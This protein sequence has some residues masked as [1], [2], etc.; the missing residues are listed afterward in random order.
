[1]SSHILLKGGT[2]F[3][4]TEV[5]AEGFVEIDGAR[6]GRVGALRDLTSDLDATVIDTAGCTVSPGFI[7]TH[8][9][10]LHQP[11]ALHLSEGATA[12]WGANYLAGVLRSGVTTVRDLGTLSPAIFGLKQS[13]N[14][15]DAPGPR[16][17]CA[18]CAICMTGGHGW[19]ELSVEADGPEGV[20]KAARAQL[21]AGADVVKLMATGGA[22]T[23]G[24]PGATQLSRDELEAGV[25][26]AHNAGKPAAAHALGADGIVNALEA[27]VDSVE[28][29]AFL[30]DRGL[31]LMLQRGTALCP[32]LSI[33]HRI[34]ARG[35]AA[36][37][38]AFMIEKARAITTPHMQSIRRAVAAGV[39]IIF[40][41][42]AGSSYLPVGDIGEEIAL[43][44]EAGMRPTEILK[45]MT[46]TAAAVTRIDHVTGS[47]RQNLDADVV[48]LGGDATTDIAAATRIARVFRAGQ[49]IAIA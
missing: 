14:R 3:T 7:D 12:I 37:D 5:I 32:T 19:H 24:Q 40:G 18:G 34:V 46:S 6:I 13:L 49:E 45:A 26:T 43:M 28:H 11:Q 36:G 2:I 4:G 47:L 30:D 31:D 22:G 44:A 1:M 10:I 42:D 9:H 48:V 20:R 35:A 38:P 23:P 33:Y 29:A 8:A 27:G 41:T 39:R 17:L 21:K 15:G 25:T 16:L